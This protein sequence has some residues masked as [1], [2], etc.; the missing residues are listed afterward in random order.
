MRIGEI[1]RDEH[2]YTDEQTG[3]LKPKFLL[4]LALPAKGDIVARLI[5]SK[6][7]SFRQED[8]R[9]QHGAPYP[10]FYLGIPGAPLGR[11][12]WVD[13]RP[14]DDLDTDSFRQRMAK[15]IIRLVRRIEDPLLRQ[16]LE[17]A[18]NAEDTTRQQ[19]KHIRDA[20]ARMS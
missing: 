5:T 9:C 1:Y 19:E 8:P 3:Q 15:Q 2:F 16:I 4:L 10:G 12:S 14:F 18:A 17:C 11:K 7:E 13:L 20:L 6:Y